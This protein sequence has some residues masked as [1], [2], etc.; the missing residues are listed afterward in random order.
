MELNTH[1]PMTINCNGKLLDLAHPQVMGILNITPDSFYPE[2]RKQSD[3]EIELRAMAIH[4]EG[5]SIIDIGAYSSRPGAADISREE[6]M[7]RLRKGLGAVRRVLPESIVSVDTFRADV[8]KMC[9]EEYGVDM[10]NDISAG[11]L[12]GEMFKTVSM[13]NVPYVIMHMK[14]NP[15]TM[16]QDTSYKDIV[17]EE[18]LYFSK[19]INQLHDLGVND[20]IVDPGFGFSKTLEQN[21]LLMSHMEEL[22]ELGMPILVGI[23]RKSMIY[24]LLGGT[25]DGALNGT[26]VLNTV[27]LSKGSD[28]L[29]VHDVKACVEAVAIYCK[30]QS[31]S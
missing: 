19:K 16:Q 21:Y 10:I 11:E 1:K 2:S 18:I 28:I 30:L 27:A 25:P 14:G 13:L 24:K 20:I 3:D 23:S 31:N 8:A 6:E 17:G 12:D 26:T 15:R 4:S 22:K 29:R 9:V 5:A 7:Q